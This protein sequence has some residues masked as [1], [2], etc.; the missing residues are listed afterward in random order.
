MRIDPVKVNDQRKV[1]LLTR[2]H[3]LDSGLPELDVDRLAPRTAKGPDIQTRELG[4]RDIDAAR[5]CDRTAGKAS[6]PRQRFPR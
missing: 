5:S 2:I 6:E 4:R 3:H 1:K